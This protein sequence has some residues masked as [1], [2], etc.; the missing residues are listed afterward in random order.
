[1]TTYKYVLEIDDGEA[2]ALNA[3]LSLLKEKCEFE[4]SIN[5]CAPYTA[6]LRSIKNIESKLTQNAQQMSGN[7]F[8]Q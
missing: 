4:T 2:I 1:M 8:G 6:W 3:A 7:S 5:P